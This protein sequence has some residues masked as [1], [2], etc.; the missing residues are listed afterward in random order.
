MGINKGGLKS[1]GGRWVHH[2]PHV[3][4]RCED[5]EAPVVLVIVSSNT[6]ESPP[7]QA[8]VG[9]AYSLEEECPAELTWNT[10][11]LVAGG[12]EA[13]LSDSCNFRA[14]KQVLETRKHKYILIS[15]FFGSYLC[16]E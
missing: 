4:L 9:D 3:D 5:L 8:R 15:C 11:F 13:F 10:S 1:G 14:S 6:L 12:T 2:T 16:C 7:S